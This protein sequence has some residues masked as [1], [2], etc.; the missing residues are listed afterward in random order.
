MVHML[1]WIE[2][3]SAK[4]MRRIVSQFPGRERMRC[5]TGGDCDGDIIQVDAG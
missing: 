1:Q 2:G 5:F 4:T 3:D